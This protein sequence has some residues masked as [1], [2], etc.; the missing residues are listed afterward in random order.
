M[1]MDERGR[2]DLQAVE[3]IKQRIVELVEEI[4]VTHPERLR[5][6][7]NGKYRQDR[8]LAWITLRKYLDQLKN[9]GKIREEIITEGKRRTISLIRTNF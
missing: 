5:N 6:A 7:Y 8:K 3:T 1:K 2:P 9:E 4:V